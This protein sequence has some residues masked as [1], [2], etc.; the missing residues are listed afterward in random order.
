VIAIGD[1]HNDISMI[2]AAGLGVAMANAEDAV[3]AIADQVTKEGNNGQGI[4]DILQQ[5]FGV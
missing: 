5:Y 1:N 3:K 4:L 2:Q